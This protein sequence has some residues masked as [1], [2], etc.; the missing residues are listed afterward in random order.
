MSQ[1]SEHERRAQVAAFARDH[2]GPASEARL[3]REEVLAAVLG[4]LAGDRP[5][6]DA[7]LAAVHAAIDD[8]PRLADEFATYFL[9][10]LMKMGKV[11]MSMSS[12]LRRFLDTGDLVMSVFGDMWSGLGKLEFQSE[13][14][15][16]KLFQ[17]RMTWKAADRWRQLNTKRR[18]E[19]KRDAKPVDEHE[20]ADDTTDP[21]QLAWHDEVEELAMIL[22]QLSDREQKI[23]TLHS[24]GATLEDVGTALDITYDAARVARRR[25]L[26]HAKQ[27]RQERDDRA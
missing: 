9:T 3:R 16:R 13:G 2:L 5:L 14:S 22:A 19:D 18:A 23:L 11:S 10:D 4:E 27:I 12:K 1:D 21:S 7:V 17:Q 15:F 26:E 6:N 20:V 8:D 25:A 24:Q